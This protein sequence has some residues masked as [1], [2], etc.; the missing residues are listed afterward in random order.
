MVPEIKPRASDIAKQAFFCWTVSSVLKDATQ[1]FIF[2]AAQKKNWR[3][4]SWQRSQWKIFRTFGVEIEIE[5]S[6]RMYMH[7]SDCCPGPKTF[8]YWVPSR[9]L[10]L[11]VQD[12]EFH[13]PSLGEVELIIPRK[14]SPHFPFWGPA[15]IE[16]KVKGKWFINDSKYSVY[17]CQVLIFCPSNTH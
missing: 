11:W 10:S 7:H 6:S 15:T 1:S 16:C 8:Q 4:K 14:C 2:A 17:Y 9:V 13:S 12:T 5:M 3:K